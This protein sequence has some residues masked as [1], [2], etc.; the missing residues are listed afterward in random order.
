MKVPARAAAKVGSALP[1]QQ[2]ASN[3]AANVELRVSLAPGQ[4]KVVSFAGSYLPS[5]PQH[6]AGGNNVVQ[7]FDEVQGFDEQKE[8][9]KK[10]GKRSMAWTE[11]YSL[12]FAP[13]SMVCRRR[14][15]RRQH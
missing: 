9:G 10:E 2:H 7:D 11:W 14:R 4:P 15:R 1:L 12:H 3:A 5:D 13:R 6:R 8:K